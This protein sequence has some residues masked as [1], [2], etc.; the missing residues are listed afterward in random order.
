MV[1]LK[2]P[3]EYKI[4]TAVA[5]GGITEDELNALGEEGWEMVA[6]NE[7]PPQQMPY[8]S[9]S[10]YTAGYNRYIFKRPKGV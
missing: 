2:Q 5:F 1:V 3:W 9:G 10:T 6:L 7:I 4:V 8:G